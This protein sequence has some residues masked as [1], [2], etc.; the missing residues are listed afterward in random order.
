MLWFKKSTLKLKSKIKYQLRPIRQLL[1]LDV[2]S[3]SASFISS[4]SGIIFAF[5][6]IHIKYQV[7]IAFWAHCCKNNEPKNTNRM[8][9]IYHNS[10]EQL[11][12]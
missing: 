3:T 4:S 12:E 9:K 2:I 6:I 7:K 10:K 8:L 1:V 5:E 11:L